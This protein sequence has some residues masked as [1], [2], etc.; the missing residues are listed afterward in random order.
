M[1]TM[2][3]TGRG[4]GL[5]IGSPEQE[6]ARGGLRTPATGQPL[7][8]STVYGTEILVDMDGVILIGGAGRRPKRAPLTVWQWHGRAVIWIWA[9]GRNPSQQ[10]RSSRN[11]C[12]P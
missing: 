6:C 5:P 8:A 4:S 7:C 11:T 12:T 9:S 10:G 1:R 3:P 2:A